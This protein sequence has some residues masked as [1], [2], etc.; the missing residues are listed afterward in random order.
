MVEGLNI[1]SVYPNPFNPVTNVE[2]TLSESGS[3]EIVVFDVMG[4]HIETLYNGYQ[5]DGG[6]SITWN[7]G[8]KSSGI[9]YIQIISNNNIKTQKVVL[10]K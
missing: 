5:S 10:L 6:H 1:N 2:Y 4:R 7:A 3:V 9:Y 8:N